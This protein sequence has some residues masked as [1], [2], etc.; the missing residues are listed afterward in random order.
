[1]ELRRM[2]RTNSRLLS[3]LII[4]ADHLVSGATAVAVMALPGM[5]TGSGDPV[6]FR[7]LGVALVATFLW[8]L[9]FDQFGLYGSQRRTELLSLLRRLGIAALLSAATLAV[10]STVI[11][12]PLAP[13]FPVI[14][15]LAQLL[16]LGVF[17]TGLYGALRIAR[18][19]GRN[20]RNL[21]IIGSGPRA[22]AAWQE[23]QRNPGWGVRLIGFADDSESPFDP[24]LTGAQVYKLSD[25][26]GLFRDQVVDEILVA[27]PRSM[28]SNIS[29]V[30]AVC[31]AVGVP[32]TL[33]S[34]LFGEFL[35]PPRT[36][37]F[38]QIPALSFSVVHHSQPMLMLKRGF[39]LTIAS[40]LLLV[41]APALGI[42]A[43]LIKATSPG[44][45]LFRQVRCGLYGRRFDML[46]LR[47]MYQDAELRR[48]EI[49]HLNEASGPVFKI[50][51]DPRVT[52]VGRYLRRW[53]LDEAPQLWNVIRGDMSLVGPRPPIPAEVA[54]YETFQRRRLSMRPGIT[55]LWQVAGR[56]TI[57]FEDWVRLDLQYIDGW[58]LG[59]DLRILART[60]PAVLRGT[61]AS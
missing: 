25:L 38:G 34:D 18:R 13:Q 28:L 47:T 20:Y 23:I 58:S 54:Q 21:L 46:K 51:N 8:P 9:L 1:M 27:C 48:C 32:V 59:K 10:V 49:E 22:R 56:S 57:G 31:A 26:P 37:S 55:C 52:P 42:A 30:I 40:A 44:P 2:L 45:V 19:R 29:E 24:E 12:A 61:G 17:R 53:S 41:A 15:A 39:D 33:M 3:S 16:T 35:P 6:P 4:A 43:L 11:A 60:I 14:C 7:L 36:A 5:M 50:R